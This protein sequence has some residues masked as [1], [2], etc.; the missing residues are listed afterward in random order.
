MGFLFGQI[1]Q[2]L[3]VIDKKQL[4]WYVQVVDFQAKKGPDFEGYIVGFYFLAIAFMSNA[5]NVIDEVVCGSSTLSCF[6]QSDLAVDLFGRIPYKEY[7]VFFPQ[8]L[9]LHYW[10]N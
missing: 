1:V 2:Q 4:L 10:Q 5:L 6:L 9:L 3:F 7:I 8:R